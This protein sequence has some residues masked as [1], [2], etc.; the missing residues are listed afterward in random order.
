ML[1]PSC[2]KACHAAQTARPRWFRQGPQGDPPCPDMKGWHVGCRLPH[3]RMWCMHMSRR[4]LPRSPPGTS[5]ARSGTLPS[6]RRYGCVLAL[7]T[8]SLTSCASP[9]AV[10]RRVTSAGAAAGS[11]LGSTACKN[12][13]SRSTKRV[14]RVSWRAASAASAPCSA[15]RHAHAGEMATRIRL[16]K[17]THHCTDCRGI[18]CSAKSECF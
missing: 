13:P 9:H 8:S 17:P 6:S 10:G 14:R 16:S 12:C 1:P 5:T 18:G 11:L 15:D 3:L 2:P 4:S 7:A